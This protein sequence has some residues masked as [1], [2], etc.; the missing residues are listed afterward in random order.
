M[1]R[2][3]FRREFSASAL[4]FIRQLM[5]TRGAAQQSTLTPAFTDGQ[6]KEY[7]PNLGTLGKSWQDLVKDQYDREPRQ[8][9]I[10]EGIL[11]IGFDDY[12]IGLFG[13]DL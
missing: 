7:R 3:W 5:Y 1:S 8:D 10:V 6:I 4:W 2:T 11:R 9:A 13:R 12:H